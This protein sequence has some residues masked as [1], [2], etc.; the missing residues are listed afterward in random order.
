MSAL[1]REHIDGNVIHS[2]NERIAA[3]A[4]LYP[5]GHP[6]SVVSGG[7]RAIGRG[8]RISSP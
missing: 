8:A 4:C 5:I 2:A 1:E 3:N 7:E 6:A